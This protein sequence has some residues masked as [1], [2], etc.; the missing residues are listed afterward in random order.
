MSSTCDKVPENHFK[1]DAEARRWYEKHIEGNTD[2][3]FPPKID[4]QNWKLSEHYYIEDKGTSLS[5][6][7][8]VTDQLKR[9]ASEVAAGLAALGDQPPEPKAR[10]VLTVEEQHKQAMD[11][12]TK[13][14][15]KLQKLVL[16][17]FARL[18]Q[19]KRQI[20]E[21]IFNALKLGLGKCRDAREQ[22]L[23]DLH[24]LRSLPS[25]EEGALETIEKVL[26]ISKEL[27]EGHATLQEALAVASAPTTADLKEEE[28]ASSVGDVGTSLQGLES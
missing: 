27:L 14:A 19:L 20:H 4:D 26:H 16:S 5:N 11:K 25:E 17:T 2:P 10:K 8:K 6:V 28:T 12:A 3:D 15:N 13:A 21:H 9:D 18:P 23:D 24:D 1:D 7:S 22:A